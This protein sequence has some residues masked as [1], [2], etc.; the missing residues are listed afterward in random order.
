MLKRFFGLYCSSWSRLSM[1]QRL[2]LPKPLRHRLHLAQSCSTT[3]GSLY[4]QGRLQPTPRTVIVHGVGCNLPC[5]YDDPRVV[6]HDA[7]SGLCRQDEVGASQEL[8]PTE[9]CG[10]LEVYRVQNHNDGELLVHGC[11]HSL[12][13]CLFHSCSTV[14]LRNMMTVLP[15]E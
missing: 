9:Q 1:P 5:K 12:I 10:F 15:L 13:G 11:S 6:D 4:L 7:L 8:V 3:R 2:A 14:L